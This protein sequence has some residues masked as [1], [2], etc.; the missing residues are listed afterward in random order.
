MRISIT[1]QQIQYFRDHSY[2]E[3]EDLL[4]EKQL[5]SLKEETLVYLSSRSYLKNFI[6]GRDLFRRNSQV[7]KLV[8][9]VQ[10]AQFASLFTNHDHLRIAFDQL[11]TSLPPYEN[12]DEAPPLFHGRYNLDQMSPIQGLVC[13]LLIN[14]DA[15]TPPP[16]F[17][18]KPGNGVYF[19]PNWPIDFHEILHPTQKYL[20]IVYTKQHSL[21]RFQPLDPAAHELKKLGYGFGDSLEHA[22]HPL[23]FL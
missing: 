10:L 7:K 5:T 15:E 3:F 19:S 9:S 16:S 8:T 11:L 21:Y 23:L 2:I 12:P 20:L 18:S 4:S 17:P 14:I 1:Q 13:G 22:N 6:A